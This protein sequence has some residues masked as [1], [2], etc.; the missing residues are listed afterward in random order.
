MKELTEIAKLQKFIAFYFISFVILFI[1]FSLSVVG[2]ETFASGDRLTG[3]AGTP[4]INLTKE[5]FIPNDF[6]VAAYS[7]K[8]N[9]DGTLKWINVNQFDNRRLMRLIKSS[10]KSGLTLWVADEKYEKPTKVKGIK[11]FFTW[12]FDK[13][14][15]IEAKEG[16]SKNVTI[17]EFPTIYRQTAAPKVKIS[18]D[19]GMATVTDKKTGDIIN[20][21]QQTEKKEIYSVG[22]EP[23][24]I[25][26]DYY[27]GS[28]F[29]KIRINAICNHMK[30]NKKGYCNGCKQ[31]FSI[32]IVKYNS[33]E[34]YKVD[35]GV[36]LKVLSAPVRAR[37]YEQEK[38]L[39]SI[40][41]GKTV[42]VIGHGYNAFDN[43]WYL[44]ED[45]NWIFGGNVKLINN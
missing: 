15:L 26:N 6:K 28:K 25:G 36:S 32:D 16:F 24:E 20:V 22:Y 18:Y 42:K 19:N 34:E 44:L 41:Q 13:M 31:E 23:Y 7:I 14:E 39:Y 35:N 37:P 3:S 8:E 5:T 1:M 33:P 9:K 30:Y 21:F 45:G 43:R 29:I 10:G 27:M 38:T 11:T 12:F 40:S 4:Q 2:A 17:I